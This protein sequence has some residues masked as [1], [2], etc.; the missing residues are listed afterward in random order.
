MNRVRRPAA[1]SA[2]VRSQ[3]KRL[4]P[5]S[6]TAGRAL[7]AI[8]L[9]EKRCVLLRTEGVEPPNAAQDLTILRFCR[10][11]LEI[12]IRALA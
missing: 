11:K 8:H 1:G 12:V 3:L 6:D 10:R 2:A 5:G 4:V 7:A 9:L